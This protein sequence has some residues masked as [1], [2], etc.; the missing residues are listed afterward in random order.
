MQTFLPYRS[1][2]RSARA[3]D[4]RRLGKQRVEALQVLRALEI[5]DYGWRHH[6][7]VHMWRGYTEA[8]VCYACAIVAEWTRRG[9]RDACRDA[10]LE[11]APH[12]RSQRELSLAGALPP[13]LGWRALHRS[14]R[15]ALVRKDPEHYRPLFPDVPPDLPYVWPEPAG[16]PPPPEPFSAWALRAPSAE[17]VERCRAEGVARLLRIERGA[18]PGSKRARQVGA[19]LSEARAGDPIVLVLGRELLAGVIA[20]PPR[21]RRHDHVRSVRWLEPIAR[22]EL[23]APAR[24]Q[25][26][27]LF[28]ALRGED[29]LRAWI[30]EAAARGA[31]GAGRPPAAR[32]RR[33]PSRS[34]G[35][36]SPRR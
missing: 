29:E 11:F 31:A 1:F 27:R 7:V 33:R 3:L 12:V 23:R 32:A 14:H 15:S 10:I 25:D 30:G 5:E 13:W 8:L 9:F 17:T 21:T 4:S 20:G 24:L 22:S 28:F 35:R 16:P 19:F 34:P 36:R 6:P 18:P 26:P 2:E